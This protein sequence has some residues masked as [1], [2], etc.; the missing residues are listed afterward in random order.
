MLNSSPQVPPATPSI[1]AAMRRVTWLP[2][3]IHVGFGSPCPC[4]LEYQRIP[5]FPRLVNVVIELSR[6]CMT[7]A[8]TVRSLH[9]R[10]LSIRMVPRGS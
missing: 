6:C 3:G 1:L 8:I 2:I 9:C 10:G 7:S 4:L 5:S